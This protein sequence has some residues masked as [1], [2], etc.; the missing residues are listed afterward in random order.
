MEEDFQE[1]TPEVIGNIKRFKI[2]Y[3]FRDSCVSNLI[4]LKKCEE[5]HRYLKRYYCS[6]FSNLWEKCQDNREK[7]IITTENLTPV[8]SEKR[9]LS[10]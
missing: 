2:P 7:K 9:Y 8:P 4:D 6:E 5:N 1:F 10:Y 3:K